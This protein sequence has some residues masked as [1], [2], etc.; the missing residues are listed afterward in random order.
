MYTL[1]ELRAASSDVDDQTYMNL[2][3][4]N[5]RTLYDR[6][7]AFQLVLSRHGVP[8]GN[9]R[10]TED[11]GILQDPNPVPIRLSPYERLVMYANRKESQVLNSIYIYNIEPASD[12]EKCIATAECDD[13]C[14]SF[15]RGVCIDYSVHPCFLIPDLR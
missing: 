6:N 11:E 12:S 4:I 14:P 13:I 3:R 5:S 2:Y 9:D 10:E 8:E 15:V 1:D 7:S